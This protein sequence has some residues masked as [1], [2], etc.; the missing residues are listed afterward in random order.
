MT[1]NFL[2]ILTKVNSIKEEE[3]NQITLIVDELKIDGSYEINSPC[4]IT[5]RCKTV[6]KC[7][8]FEISS[9]SVCLENIF[10]DG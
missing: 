7:K 5:S 3:T 6:I 4:K 10:F 9:S 1:V 8:T 2:S